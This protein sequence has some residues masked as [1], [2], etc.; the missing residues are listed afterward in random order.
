MGKK[1]FFKILL[2]CAC[3]RFQVGSFCRALSKIYRKQFK[4][5][6]T[7]HCAVPQVPRLLEVCLL[8]SFR[9][10]LRLFV[11]LCPWPFSCV[12]EELGGMGYFI[13]AVTGSWTTLGMFGRG[14]I[15]CKRPKVPFWV[16]GN[17]SSFMTKCGGEE[18]EAS[19]IAKR[20]L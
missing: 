15:G 18:K 20:L 14:Q 1:L 7:H 3:W 5:P 2:L 9:I 11:L 16:T 10:F 6:G 13:L 4:N 17:Q 19:E 8:C 12:S